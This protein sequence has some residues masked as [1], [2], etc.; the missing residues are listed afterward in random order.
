MVLID[1]KTSR[2]LFT[3]LLFALG[4]GFL[5]AAR[6]T[7]FAF[8]FAIFFAYLMDPAVSVAGDVRLPSSTPSCW[9]E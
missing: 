1:A 6:R 4:I 2:V 5:Y 8:L 7:L 3:G 9:A